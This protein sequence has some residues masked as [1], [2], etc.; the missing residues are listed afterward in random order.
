MTDQTTN[1]MPS[2]VR[3]LK[4]R[5]KG[6]PPS[7]Y[8]REI[9]VEMLEQIA[10]GS[11]LSKICEQDGMPTPTTFRKWALADKELWE[12]L[13]AARSLKADSLFDEALDMARDLKKEPGTAQKVRAYDVAMSQLRWSAG[14]LDP[15]R[16]SDRSSISVVVP[17]QI[18][19]TLD[20]GQGVAVTE[21]GSIYD[22]KATVVNEPEEPVDDAGTQA[23]KRVGKARVK[24]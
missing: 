20:L 22:I 14:K 24:S 17:I 1:P 15:S 16:F 5:T 2:Q 18:N 13:Q 11:T 8:R 12:A 21:D 6:R 7:V 4:K 19:T 23:T 10:E 9:A 3:A